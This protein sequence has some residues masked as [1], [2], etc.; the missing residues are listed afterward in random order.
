MCI[1][2]SRY[3]KSRILLDGERHVQLALRPVEQLK[4]TWTESFE[5]MKVRL[6]RQF[7]E[8]PNPA[9]FLARVSYSFPLQQTTLPIAK[10]RLVRLL[11]G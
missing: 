5:Q 9:V 2:D 1:R 11:M 6:A 7:P 4:K 8:W 10:R 3:A